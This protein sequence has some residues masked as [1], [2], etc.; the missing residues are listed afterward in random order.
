MAALY[1]VPIPIAVPLMVLI[2]AL[3]PFTP[4]AWAWV[5]LTTVSR[6]IRQ[7]RAPGDLAKA[8]GRG[9]GLTTVLPWI[10]LVTL[11]AMV[12]FQL[13]TTPLVFF[14][15]LRTFRETITWACAQLGLTPEATSPQSSP[16]EE[17]ISESTVS[18]L[19]YY[20]LP[21][22]PPMSP[23]AIRLLSIHPAPFNAP[24][25]GTITTSTLSSSSIWKSNPT[26]DAI[27]Y[28][29]DPFSNRWHSPSCS[30]ASEGEI[31]SP[32]TLDPV[33]P[34]SLVPIMSGLE[35]LLILDEPAQTW[36]IMPLMWTRAAALRRVR[37]ETEVRTVWMDHV[38]IKQNDTW[39]KARQVEMM[40][41]IFCSARRVVVYT[42]EADW[43]GLTDRLFDWVNS[44]PRREL[45]VP[46]QAWEMGLLG[47]GQG[48][49][50]RSGL[51]ESVGTALAQLM[52]GRGKEMV[53]L[54]R[55]WGKKG[56]EVWDLL[57]EEY[58]VGMLG[59][60]P[61]V[62]AAPP[63]YLQ[64]AL[65]AYFARSWFKRVWPLEEVLLPGLSK[66]EF[67]CG[68]RTTSGERMA[69]LSSLLM[70][71]THSK[72]LNMGRVLRLF[73][74]PVPR[75]SPRRSRL[76]DVL[77]A[78]A[79]RECSD[80]R[81]KI[82]GVLN[83]ARRLDGGLAALG[84]GSVDYRKPTGEVYA[85]Y[86]AQFIRWHGPGFFLA[87]IK[88]QPTE[89]ISRPRG[90]PSWA[91][92]WTAPWPNRR[93]LEELGAMGRPRASNEKD[94]VRDFETDGNG[95]MIMKIMRP[96]IVRGFFTRDGHIDG[97][98]GTLIE[99]VRQLPGDEVLVE[100]YPGLALLLRRERGEPNQYTFVLA[101]PHALSREGVERI[102][103]NWGKV[104]MYQQDLGRQEVRG[105]PAGGY[106][107]LP[108][109]YRIV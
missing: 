63:E 70:E 10:A 4:V 81:D 46:D 88:P 18:S 109:V 2:F 83:I 13:A 26:Y 47:L 62:A 31:P 30:S 101:C 5:I 97:A 108:G 91:A 32:P 49:C 82:Y 6:G 69:H 20:N 28:T 94:C 58:R 86:S 60:P 80:P 9:I 38:C 19:P 44:L 14:H 74:Q 89:S 54:W 24:L 75:R 106:L 22:L 105:S 107:S 73:Q 96:R 104:V 72:G 3:L 39:E 103:A 52:G 15:H 76:L 23:T 55:M 99:N 61:T 40:D 51:T 77:I 68:S 85:L 17:P 79:H 41:R 25:R 8:I 16:E 102:V 34:S 11:W 36:H 59:V 37:S 100:M 57:R 21:P 56:Q 90:L 48:G 33:L 64:W 67:V 29:G 71:D 95:R 7:R 12:V 1:L 78:T 43:D 92:D 42:G 98:K 66:V 27:S 65:K 53:R 35:T 87:L 45:N 93:A 84:P 50:Y